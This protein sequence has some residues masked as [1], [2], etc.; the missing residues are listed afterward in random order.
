MLLPQEGW[1]Q[2][3]SA[4]IVFMH[5]PTGKRLCLEQAIATLL[6]SLCLVSALQA[7]QDAAADNSP[8]QWVSDLANP[9]PQLRRAAEFHLLAAGSETLPAVR[10]GMRSFDIEI[11]S[12]C[13]VLFERIE[14]QRRER[15]AEQFLSENQAAAANDIEL[16]AWPAF[17]AFADSEDALA[18]KLFL[19]MCDE[20]PLVFEDYEIIGEQTAAGLKKSARLIFV[21]E[22]NA[23]ASAVSRAIAY[24]FLA[25]L[26]TSR[27]ADDEAKDLFD[28]VESLEAVHYFSNYSN[29][30]VVRQSDFREIIESCFSKWVKRQETFK[31]ISEEAKYRLIYKTGN[32][33]LMRDLEKDFGSLSV[34][35][36]LKF[37][38]T[39]S[40]ATSEEEDYD[41]CHK[42][43]KEP[44]ADETVAIST[45][46]R[47]SP[48]KKIDVSIGRLAEGILAIAIKRSSKT[49]EPIKTEAVFGSYPYSSSPFL[50]VADESEREQMADLLKSDSK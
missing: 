29:S 8:E 46:V 16:K 6:L 43:L 11:A 40:N 44:L 3:N 24:L 38:E 31:R 36:K 33:P 47:K 20:L 39:V 28:K 9:N 32:R 34:S 5:Y 1:K 50:I 25:D 18:K 13:K 45:R 12:R 37:I 48:A 17:K 7:Q 26:A 30:E 35:Q 27:V 19:E 49:G 22:E 23:N 41:S 10:A 15:I 42:W 4:T 2:L 21:G 14:I